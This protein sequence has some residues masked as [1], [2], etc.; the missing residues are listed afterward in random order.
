MTL[1]FDARFERFWPA[2]QVAL[3]AVYGDIA[4]AAWLASVREQVGAAARARAQDLQN[5]D[6]DRLQRPDWFQASDRI[7]YTTYVDRFAGRLRSV[8]DHIDYLRELGVTYL[9]PL[10]ISKPRQGENDGGFAV[11]DYLDIDPSIGGWDDLPALCTALRGAGISLVMDVVCNHTA[12]DHA[13]ASA[14][15]AGDADKRAFYHVLTQPSDVEAYER[16]LLDVFPSTAPGNFT[17]C[18]ELGGWVW[19]TF[20]PYQ[21]DLN[22]ANPAVF[23]AMLDVLLN[24]ANAGVE[25]FRLDSAPFLWK[26]RGTT[27]RGLPQT[28]LIVQAWRALLSIAAPGVLLKAEAIEQ[29]QDVVAFFG[30]PGGGAECQL[31]Y[32]S[33]MMAALWASLAT[34][35]AQ[36]ARS[37]I[38]AAA[39]RPTR[40]AWINYIRCHDDIIWNVLS[41]YASSE[42]LRRL[43]AFYAGETPGSFAR[44]ERFQALGEDM[45]SISGMAADLV[46][47]GEDS[48]PL[49]LSRLK[50]LY[51]VIF[52]LDGLPLIYMGDELG[53]RGDTDYGRDPARA[54]DARWLHRPKMSWTRAETRHSP[55]TCA[56]AIFQHIAR[57][58]RLR[59]ANPVVD[60][61][62]RAEALATDAKAALAFTRVGDGRAIAVIANVGSQTLMV[63]AD[64]LHLGGRD[65]LTD[66]FLSGP[67][68]PL[69][70]YQVRWLETAL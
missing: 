39:V 65:L 3:E 12:D 4:D 5:M 66:E 17:H 46:G 19:T 23:S 45:W 57:L 68:V 52:A 7:G 69:E 21:W 41:P 8:A 53:L 54:G 20:F 51:S 33:A 34:G 9:H 58:A 26:E 31:A 36:I 70:P 1:D 64:D 67:E 22:Y 60:A 25:G 44:G 30:P 42:D 29:V 24:L 48:D 15:R 63:R 59:A 40:G 56:G 47:L 10:P 43:G 55:S 62:S 28:H 14:A 38:E 61:K 27:S 18:P 13:W 49:A 50:M 6:Q 11:A 2:A 37:V 16:D 35:D 32:N